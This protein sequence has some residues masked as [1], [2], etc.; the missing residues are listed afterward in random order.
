[1]HFLILYYRLKGFWPTKEILWSIYFSF[2]FLHC[3]QKR[4]NCKK[5]PKE[6]RTCTQTT[7]RR[8]PT[9]KPSVKCRAIEEEH[10]SESIVDDSCNASIASDPMKDQKQAAKN[11]AGL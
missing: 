10:L 8:K 1:M 2:F 7:R 5:G 9:K 11:M 3:C 6:R 4:S